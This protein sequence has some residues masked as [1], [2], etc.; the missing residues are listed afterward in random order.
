MKP[1]EWMIKYTP[2]TAWI[3]RKGILIWLA[4]YAGLFG[5]GSYLVSIFFHNLSGMFIGWLTI[6]VIKSGFYIVHSSEPLKLWLMIRRPQ[7]SWISRGLIMVILFIVFGAIQLGLSFWTPGTAGEMI[8]EILTGIMALGII[9]YT[10]FA[11]SNVPGI[12]F[13][14]SVLLPGLFILL[15][16]LTGFTLIIGI[17]AGT[18]N[19]DIVTVAAV[20][21][22]ILIVCLIIT[23][24]YLYT[25][26]Y[27][28]LAARQSVRELIRGKMTLVSAIGVILCGIVIPL[29]TLMLII[30]VSGISYLSLAIVAICTV[31]I[32]G[33]ALT[34]SVLKVGRYNTLM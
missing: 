33:L 14:H 11:L 24:I 18:P 8:F 1:Y 6:L 3:E 34:Y 13:W 4:F 22:T 7:T 15:A 27:I 28:G 30:F 21:A 5:S 26:T 12:P 19:F 20:S 25:T 29:T 32:G 23:I 31:T 9:I 10:G 17:S 16:L 2:Q